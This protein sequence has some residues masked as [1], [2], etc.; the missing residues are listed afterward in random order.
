M[1]VLGNIVSA[2]S[3]NTLV[4]SVRKISTDGSLGD[5]WDDVAQ[6][7][8]A[9]LPAADA[10]RVGMTEGT[11]DWLRSWSGATNGPISDFSGAVLKTYHDITAGG[12]AIEQEVVPVIRGT[13]QVGSALADVHEVNE[14]RT[15]VISDANDSPRAGNIITQTVPG[16][17]T[18]GMRFENLN[19]GT[20]IASVVSQTIVD[21]SGDIT[22]PTI[23]SIV[24]A[25]DLRTIHIVPGNL[26]TDSDYD[27][28]VTVNTT[29]GEPL[30]GVGA[31][32]TDV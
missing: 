13:E 32:S 25:K 20:A 6:V 30:T 28:T 11:G 21:L 18:L 12:G 3:G 31:I 26:I 10:H 29:D 16:G 2:Y 14:Q 19:P 15:W 17:E 27:V 24:V 9:T 22:N 5:Y 8:S 4:F 1:S 7:F 23:V